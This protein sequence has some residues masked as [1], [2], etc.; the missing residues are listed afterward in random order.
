MPKKELFMDGTTRR[1][2]KA[3]R[4]SL[5]N[6]LEQLVGK[7]TMGGFAMAISAISGIPF[8][9]RIV[10]NYLNRFDILGSYEFI[11]IKD[12]KPEY[13]IVAVY[14]WDG[15]ETGMKSTRE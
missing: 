13:T 14:E 4:E 1:Y 11:S 12:K 7:A 10:V 2:F 6:L 5:S 9:S 15:D 8:P 3:N